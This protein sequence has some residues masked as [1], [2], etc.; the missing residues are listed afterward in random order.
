MR[1]LRSVVM[2]P[3]WST[4]GQPWRATPLGSSP[5]RTEDHRQTDKR[6]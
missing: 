2:L 1:P 5:A 3:D 6:I 4:G